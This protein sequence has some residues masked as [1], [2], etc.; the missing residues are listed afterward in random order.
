MVSPKNPS[1]SPIFPVFSCSLAVLLRVFMGIG[2]VLGMCF[3]VPLAQARPMVFGYVAWWVPEVAQGDGLANVDRLKFMEFKVG[4][5]G[6]VVDKSGWPE[7]WADLRGQAALRGIPIDLAYTLFSPADFNALFSSTERTKRLQKEML[8]QVQRDSV[9]GIHL[10]VEI[11]SPVQPKAAQRY[12]EFVI[13]LGRQLKALPAPKALSVFLNYAADQ[14]IYDAASLAGAD[15]VIVQGY[16]AHW[17][18]GDVAG[19][20]S[21]LKGPDA[22]TWTKMLATTQKLGLPPS[23]VLMGFPTYGYEWPVKPCS[24]RGTRVGKGEATTFG[25]V[26]L[27]AAPAIRNSVMGRVLAHGGRHDWDVGSAYYMVDA[28]D[29]S[30]LVGWYEDWWTLESKLDWVEKEGLA[31]LAF[32]PLGYDGGELVGLAARRFRAKAQR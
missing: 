24:P 6:K 26:N 30:C 9:A 19:P 31:G 18:G 2:V 14:Y 1:Y 21:P 7:K 20:V 16:D 23:R 15:H 8:E 5:E 32:F 17:L 25:R 29:G 4:P 12:R 3:V 22:V 28:H 11:F 10:D 13:D 27:L